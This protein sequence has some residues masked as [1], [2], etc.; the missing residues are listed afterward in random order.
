VIAEQKRQHGAGRPSKR[1]T[2]DSQVC[3]FPALVD[4]SVH[5]PT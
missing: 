4:I 5:A 1:H 3:H 2:L